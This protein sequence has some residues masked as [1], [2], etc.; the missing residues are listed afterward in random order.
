MQLAEIPAATYND[1]QLEGPLCVE[2]ITKNYNSDTTLFLICLFL[3]VVICLVLLYILVFKPKDIYIYLGTSALIFCIIAIRYPSYTVAGE[4]WAEVGVLYVP[5]VLSKT[6]LGNLLTL[7]AELYINA[8]GRVIAWIFVNL[9]PS[10]ASAVMGINIISLILLSLM[11]AS[12]SSGV[13]KKY[14]N[15][16]ES[17]VISVLITT[18][19]VDGE[20]IATPLITSYWAIIPLIVILSAMVLKIQVPS[21]FLIL[22]SILIFISTLSRMSYVVLI[23]ILIMYLIWFRKDLSK[24]KVGY[25]IFITSLCL[26][27][28]VASLVLRRLNGIDSDSAVGAVHIGSPIKLI[29]GVFYYQI[30][31][32][33]SLLRVQSTDNFAVWNYLCLLAL[34]LF[35]FMLFICIYKQ[36]HALYAKAIL[37][38][39]A[40]SFGQCCLQLVT[41][42]FSPLGNGVDWNIVQSLPRDRK[43]LFCY[44]AWCG[45]ALMT[46][47]YCRHFM[48]KQPIKIY[49]V[50]ESILLYFILVNACSVQPTSGMECFYDVNKDGGDW[51]NYYEMI[52]NDSYLIPI[53]PGFDWIVYANGCSVENGETTATDHIS[54]ELEADELISFYVAK[55]TDTNQLREEPYYITCYDANGNIIAPKRQVNDLNKDM[56]GFDIALLTEGV[57]KLSFSYEDGTAAYIEGSYCLAYK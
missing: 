34:V 21:K 54:L 14:I 18:C 57:S 38:L 30:Q 7:E 55:N 29:N 47:V 8:I 1:T 52:E 9:M 37:L 2:Y 22:W 5:S 39:V 27:E 41:E 12:L 20:T 24:R 15:P 40:L 56:M 45:I 35:I 43:W 6:F 48:Q 44:I 13:L 17:V 23:P 25:V 26:M 42:G 28:G 33:N 49:Q 4:A 51:D 19:L 31:T 3:T 32:I 50:T 46:F 36:K 11:G 53:A 16:L 10:L